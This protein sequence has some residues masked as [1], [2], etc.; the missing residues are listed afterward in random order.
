MTAPFQVGELVRC[1]DAS[2]C[3]DKRLKCGSIYTVSDITHASGSWGGTGP[4]PHSKTK[5]S[6]HLY[7][8]PLVWGQFDLSVPWYAATRF[9]KLENTID[10]VTTDQRTEVPA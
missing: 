3:P 6:L 10:H 9:D 4:S 5:W 1:I 7:E 2:A 8:L